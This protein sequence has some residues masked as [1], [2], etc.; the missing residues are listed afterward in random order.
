[1]I[2]GG[3]RIRWSTQAFTLLI[4]SERLAFMPF[5]AA[6]TIVSSEAGSHGGV[7]A[8][9]P[10]GVVDVGR[11]GG[12]GVIDR[13]KAWAFGVGSA[14]EVVSGIGRV[15]D[16]GPSSSVDIGVSESAP[17]VLLWRSRMWDLRAPL[18]FA[19]V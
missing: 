18:P 9:G 17:E 6:R 12:E 19:L 16:F 3:L 5:R 14:G 10:V 1:M 11:E 2:P 15:G 4:S 7:R 13:G 8:G